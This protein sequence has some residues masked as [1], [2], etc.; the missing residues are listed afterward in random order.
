MPIRENGISPF[1]GGGI[2]GPFLVTPLETKRDNSLA[3]EVDTEVVTEVE[4]KPIGAK[5]VEAGAKIP[6]PKEKY[7]TKFPL[8]PI[9]ARLRE[10]INKWIDRSFF[11]N[12]FMD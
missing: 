2:R 11:C 6:N 9:H 8:V 5:M 4:N 1:M 12:S 7:L 3:T 10:C